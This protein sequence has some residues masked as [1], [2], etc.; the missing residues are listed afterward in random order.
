MEDVVATLLSVESRDDAQPEVGVKVAAGEAFR[1]AV[2]AASPV[3]LEPIM[4][5][6]VVVPEESL[7]PVIGDL[8]Q[9]RA[10]IENLETRDDMRVAVARVALRRMFGYSTELRSLTRGRASF[11]MEFQAFDSL[12]ETP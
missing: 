10:Q 4:R 9:R 6:E 11:T 2:R 5:V 1:K 8:R 7:G 12:E 3:R